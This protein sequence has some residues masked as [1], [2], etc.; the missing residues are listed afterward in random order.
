MK[1]DPVDVTQTTPRFD[2]NWRIEFLARSVRYRMHFRYAWAVTTTFSS[3]CR[4]DNA[5]P[6]ARPPFVVGGQGFPRR[7]ATHSLSL[8][9]TSTVRSQMQGTLGRICRPP[10]ISRFV[11]SCI[12]LLSNAIAAP[13]FFSIH[14]RKPVVNTSM[15]TH[16]II[17]K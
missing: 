4:G 3:N 1:F 9:L 14:D 12:S 10:H 8:S 5:P 7:A 2:T 13:S 17:S 6:I 11:G 16:N 15:H